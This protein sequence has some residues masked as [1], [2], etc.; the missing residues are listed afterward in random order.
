MSSAPAG[1]RVALVTLG[2]GR[3]EVDSEEMAGRL[4]A[5]GWDLVADPADADVAVVNTCG[6]VEAAKKD[7]IDTVLQAADLKPDANGR[8]L[9]VTMSATL[10]EVGQ[11]SVFLAAFAKAFSG[12]AADYSKA[13]MSDLAPA[14]PATTP[15]QDEANMADYLT[16]FAAAEKTHSEYLAACAKKPAT[17]SELANAT[18]LWS[19]LIG[20]RI[21]ANVA[22]DVAKVT[23]QPYPDPRTGKDC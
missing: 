22:A 23:P 8:F 4:A 16:K 6:F 1:R 3:N 19:A 2:C 21:K 5:D 10:H 15:F 9:P 13:I 12:S 20:N 17:P 11:P 18:S 7:S 14:S